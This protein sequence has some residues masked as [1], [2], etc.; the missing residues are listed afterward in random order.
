MIKGSGLVA[1]GY[2]LFSNRVRLKLEHI[3]SD[4]DEDIQIEG[5]FRIGGDDNQAKLIRW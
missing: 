2:Q 4:Q 1:T 3:I 5:R